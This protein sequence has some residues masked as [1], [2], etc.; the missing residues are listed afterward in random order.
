MGSSIATMDSKSPTFG[1]VGVQLTLIGLFL[2]VNE[3]LLL[4][5]VDVGLVLLGTLLVAMYLV[6]SV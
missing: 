1:V 6:R 4:Y 5:L 3:W 2:S